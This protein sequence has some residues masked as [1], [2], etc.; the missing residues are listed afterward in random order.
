MSQLSSDCACQSRMKY[1]RELW[2]Q[3]IKPD[4]QSHKKQ[5]WLSNGLF[6]TRRQHWQP[7]CTEQ[8][9][10]LFFQRYR[11]SIS[12]VAG[13]IFIQNALPLLIKR[14]ALALQ[15][16]WQLRSRLFYRVDIHSNQRWQFLFLSPSLLREREILKSSTVTAVGWHR[17]NCCLKW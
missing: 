1:K 10:F 14:G 9:R 2:H 7:K 6:S 8:L 16:A 5:G 17:E 15:E 12:V 13:M 11:K 4:F 3:L